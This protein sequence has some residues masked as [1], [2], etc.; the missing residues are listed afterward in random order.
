MEGAR[1]IWPMIEKDLRIENSAREEDIL[2]ED[3]LPDRETAAIMELM[4][5]LLDITLFS[6]LNAFLH[7]QISKMTF[8]KA[9]VTVYRTCLLQPMSLTRSRALK[10]LKSISQ[11]MTFL[12][13]FQISKAKLQ[14]RNR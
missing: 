4:A 13:Q 9:A 12:N 1:E 3:R 2:A 7:F 6:N 14:D 11:P 5:E 8:S 10:E